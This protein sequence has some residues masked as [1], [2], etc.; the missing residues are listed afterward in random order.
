[1]LKLR[2]GVKIDEN[3]AYKFRLPRKDI[4]IYG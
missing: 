1:M 4:H 2:A 3:A